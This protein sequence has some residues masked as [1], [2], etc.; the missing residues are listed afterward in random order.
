M[1]LR[2]PY[3]A[4][5]K[6]NPSP[7]LQSHIERLHSILPILSLCPTHPI[8][9]VP[10]R[11]ISQLMKAAKQNHW[12]AMCGILRYL[13]GTIGMGGLCRWNRSSTD[14]RSTSSGY[15]TFVSGNLD[16]QKSKKKNV[17]ARSSAETKYKVMLNT[18]CE[19]MWIENL[20]QERFS[21][22]KPMTM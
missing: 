12:E 20:L 7:Q 5:R 19:L 4:S 9:L 10:I 14:R 6:R 15:C 3:V 18:V 1:H 22:E 8:F 11:I 16:T 21:L 2:L 13:N 17:I